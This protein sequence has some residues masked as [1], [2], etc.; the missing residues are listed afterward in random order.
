MEHESLATRLRQD[1]PASI[2]VFLV[3]VPL[4]LGIALASGAPLLSG[5]IAGVVGGIVV[6]I[7]SGSP[8]GVSGPAAGLA[9]IVLTAIETL[10]TFEAFLTAVIIAGFLQIGLG[11]LQA[12]V[13]AYYFPSSVIKGMLSGIGIIIIVKQI[14]H[15][16]GYD[17]EYIGDFYFEAQGEANPFAQLYYMFWDIAPGPLLV[18]VVSL[19][20]LLLWERPFVKAN[21]MLALLPGPLLAV[22]AGIVL[23]GMLQGVEGMR[24]TSIFFVDLPDLRDPAVLATLPRPDYGALGT[25][26][27]WTVAFTIAI[28]ASIETLLCV[29]ATDKMDPLKRITP[30]NRELVAQ[31]IGNSLS[32]FLGGLPVT[33]VIVRSSANIQSGGRTKLSAIMHGFLILFS[34]LLIPG[35]L[36]MIPLASLAAILLV[37]GYKLAKPALFTSMWRRGSHQFL[38][39]MVTV[40][41]VVLTDLLTGVALGM[42]V[43]IF[44]ILHNNYKIPFHFDPRTHVP[45]EPIRIKL[46]E[47]VSF[48][49]KASIL[50]TLSTLPHGSHV[51]IDATATALLDDDVVE[52][53]EEERRRALSR[54]ITMEVIGLEQAGRRSPISELERAIRDAAA[55]RRED[56]S[57]TGSARD[58]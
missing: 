35:L 30:S 57:W 4:C 41:G 5:L 51:V 45:G 3:A 52:I 16:L 22:I 38:P 10:G 29:E 18:A 1:V 11:M 39:F 13:V 27:V 55:R 14:P 24:M 25:M 49:N 9:V 58:E 56:L 32:G 23:G 33:Q 2:V 43:G 46:S 20:I 54:N 40:A 42:V 50:R 47:D 37:V 12:G 48:L 6:G 53:I 36:Q 44:I 7:A 26:S 17:S 34:V 21:K 31:G 28:V 19:A 8:L 15:A